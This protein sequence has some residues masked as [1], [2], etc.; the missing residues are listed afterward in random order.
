MSGRCDK[1]INSANNDVITGTRKFNTIHEA[2]P[3]FLLILK[4]KF[5]LQRG[6]TSGSHNAYLRIG[7]NINLYHVVNIVKVKSVPVTCQPGIE[8]K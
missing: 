4:C 1:F 3:V 8:E 2:N 7:R 5:V 6:A